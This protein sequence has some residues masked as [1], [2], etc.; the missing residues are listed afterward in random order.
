LPEVSSAVRALALP[1]RYSQDMGGECRGS[2]LAPYWEQVQQA[3]RAYERLLQFPNVDPD[4]VLLGGHSA[5]GHL[6]LFATLAWPNLRCDLGARHARCASKQ[7][8]PHS[9]W[10]RDAQHGCPALR[11]GRR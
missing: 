3:V 11:H 1:Y 5:G 8:L 6:A 10:L 7:A 9:R 4:A 2:A